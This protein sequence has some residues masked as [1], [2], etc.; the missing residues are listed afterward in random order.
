VLIRP[1]HS[2]TASKVGASLWIIAG[3]GAQR[4]MGKNYRNTIAEQ[5]NL[6]RFNLLPATRLA[7]QWLGKP[8]IQQL[9]IKA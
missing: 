9:D 7:K 3:C 2:K 4:R 6:T 5:Q 1:L 8:V